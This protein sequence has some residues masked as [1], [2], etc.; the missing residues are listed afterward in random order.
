MK[1]KKLRMIMVSQK[2]KVK[3]SKTKDKQK[4]NNKHK[5]DVNTNLDQETPKI[6][7]N[8]EPNTKTDLSDKEQAKQKAIEIYKKSQELMHSKPKVAPKS[9]SKVKK[10]K[11]KTDKRKV[12][13]AHNL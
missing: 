9:T 8:P 10:P 12:M 6:T 5:S 4:K 1:V 13:A 2:N 11:L 3:S 7:V